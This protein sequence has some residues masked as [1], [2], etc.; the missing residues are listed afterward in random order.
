MSLINREECWEDIKIRKAL[1]KGEELTSLNSAIEILYS[2]QQ[3]P[4]NSIMMTTPKSIRLGGKN[5]SNRSHG[6]ASLFTPRFS[7]FSIISQSRATKSYLP[8]RD[9]LTFAPYQSKL[10]LE[11]STLDVIRLGPNETPG[12]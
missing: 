5:K 3:K 8:V 9:D 12:S 2:R 7:I 10:S 11:D 6:R 1:K 4:D